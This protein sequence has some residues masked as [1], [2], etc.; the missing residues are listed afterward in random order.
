MAHTIQINIGHGAGC[1][2][3][4]RI[5][6]L[7]VRLLPSPRPFGLLYFTSCQCLGF[8]LQLGFSVDVGGIN[9]DVGRPS[10]DGIDIYSGGQK[11]CVWPVMWFLFRMRNSGHSFSTHLLDDIRTISLVPRHLSS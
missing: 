10:V 9:R 8:H 5:A 3:G 2:E 4:V 1:H 7:A 6:S 11:M